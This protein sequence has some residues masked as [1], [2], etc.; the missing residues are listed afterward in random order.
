MVSTVTSLL[1]GCGFDSRPVT[2]LCG[3]GRACLASLQAP[4]TVHKYGDSKLSVDVNM[5]LNGLFVSC[6]DSMTGFFSQNKGVIS[7]ILPK[8]NCGLQVFPLK[9]VRQT[10]HYY[11]LV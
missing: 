7:K 4:P 10:S 11:D 6:C 3:R 5:S 1:G 2:F 8:Y 9:S